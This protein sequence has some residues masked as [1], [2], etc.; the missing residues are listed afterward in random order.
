MGPMERIDETLAKYE[1]LNTLNG[2]DYKAEAERLGFVVT[3]KGLFADPNHPASQPRTLDEFK[4]FIEDHARRHDYELDL[5]ERD[6]GT[7]LAS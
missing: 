1:H 4:E 6:S 3:E 5:E 7:H 2:D